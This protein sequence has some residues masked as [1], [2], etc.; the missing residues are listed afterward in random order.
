MLRVRGRM[1]Q[2]RLAR[3]R[4]R[5]HRNRKPYPVRDRAA[6]HLPSPTACAWLTRCWSGTRPTGKA[7]APRPL[8]AHSPNAATAARRPAASDV[9]IDPVDLR[10]VVHAQAHLAGHFYVPRLANE[11][12]EVRAFSGGLQVFPAPVPDR[13]RAFGFSLLFDGFEQ[14]T[15]HG[16]GI[17][18][19]HDLAGVVGERGV[20]E[21][22]AAMPNALQSVHD[23][24]NRAGAEGLGAGE[25]ADKCVGVR[26]LILVRAGH[27]REVAVRDV[28][29][30]T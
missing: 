22:R 25:G 21:E 11:G 12:V 8:A 7:D 29:Q 30:A 10:F 16:D 28:L 23:V 18:P 3:P 6:S 9:Q 20:D 19:E 24:E 4:G 26:L 27:V 14:Q 17:G 1:L 13:Y 15:V 2:Q 5:G